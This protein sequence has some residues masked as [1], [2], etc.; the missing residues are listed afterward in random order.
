MKLVGFFT[1]TIANTN[2]RKTAMLR[3]AQAYV[4]RNSTEDWIFFIYARNL[5]DANGI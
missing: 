4:K 3:N 1:V 2:A 5:I